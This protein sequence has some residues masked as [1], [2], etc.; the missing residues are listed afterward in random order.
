MSQ[1]NRQ[2]NIQNQLKTILNGIIYDSISKTFFS[3]LEVVRMR[4][5]NQNEM[6]K[7]GYLQQR[8][9]GIINC[10]KRVVQEEGLK[11]L[12]KGNFTHILINLTS[13]TL[14]FPINS[15]IKKIINPKRE[16]GQK[17]WIASNLA[18]GLLAGFLSSIFSYPLDYARTK[19]TNDFNSPKF[20]NQKQYNGLID[21]FRKTLAS[22]GIVGFYRGYIISNFGIIIYR[23]VYFGLHGSFRHLVPQQNVFAQFGYSWTVTT[24]AGMVSYTVDTVK[25]RMMMTSG[26]PVKY[27]GSIDC[28]RYIIK[29]E[30][31]K[32]LFNGFSLT[33]IKSITSAGLLVIYDQFQ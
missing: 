29:N 19:L 23:A 25:R 32:H 1:D 6:I 27:R 7:Q 14:S 30:G 8:Y 11:A 31:F 12:W 24:T 4:L 2:P 28:F 18:A 5:Q 13:N 22:D 26:Q 9:N 10:S 20:G 33:L 17:M 3:P 21:V 16:D 15:L